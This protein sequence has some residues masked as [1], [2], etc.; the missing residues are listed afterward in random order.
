MQVVLAYGAESDRKLNIPG[1]VRRHVCH[2]K[3]L[4]GHRTML[5]GSVYPR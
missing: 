5:L 1:E 2:W 3:S 4:K